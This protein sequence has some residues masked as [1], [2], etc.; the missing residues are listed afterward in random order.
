[1]SVPAVESKVQVIADP[2]PKVV[3]PTSV[4]SKLIVSVPALLSLVSIPFVPPAIVLAVPK[5]VDELPRSPAYEI[6]EL[7]SSAFEIEVPKKAVREL[8]LKT[9]P[10]PVKSDIVSP[11]TVIEP[12]LTDPVTLAFVETVKVAAETEPV[13][14]RFVENAPAPTTSRATVGAVVPTPRRLENEAVPEVKIC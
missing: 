12:A 7:S 14:L 4:E 9:R 13:T 1:M 8:P 6:V 2:E 11:P 10:V 5:E 3:V